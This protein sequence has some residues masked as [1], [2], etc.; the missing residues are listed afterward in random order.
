MGGKKYI[1]NNI[2]FKFAVD[3]HGLFGNDYSAAKA[4]GNELRGLIGY[5]NCEIPELNVPLMALVDYRGF[6]L[7]AM[8]ILPVSPDTIIY[9]SCDAGRNI[10]ARDEKFN[11]I[12]KKAAE[13]LHIKPHLCRIADSTEN[14]HIDYDEEDL[15]L[16]VLN[17]NEK[18]PLLSR[19][20][21]SPSVE[22][23]LRESNETLSSLNNSKRNLQSFGTLEEYLYSPADLEGH[24]GHDGK[25]YLLDFSRVLPPETP[26]PKFKNAHLTRLLRLEFVQQ[27]YK[28]LCPDAFSGFIRTSEFESIHNDEIREATNHL[29]NVLIPKFAKELERRMQ[30]AREQQSLHKFALTETIHAV[31]INCRHAGLLRKYMNDDE[32]KQIVLAEIVARNI[33]NNLRFKLREKMKQLGLPLEEPYRRLVIDYLN[34]VFGNTKNSD[35]YWD[36]WLKKD[37]LFNFTD[38]LSEEESQPSFHLKVRVKGTDELD[39]KF[40]SR[41]FERVVKMMGLQ[42]SQSRIYIFTTE[43]PFNDADLESIGE[44]VKQMNIM[45][46]AQGFFYQVN[47][48]LNRAEDPVSAKRCYEIAIKKFEEA[49]DSNPNNKDLL[50]SIS[51][52]LFLLI[53]EECKDKHQDKFSPDDPLVKKAEEYSL[54]AISAEPKYDSFSLFRY[55][56]FLERCN[57]LHAA[58]DYYLMALESD[59]DNP[60]C[61]HCYGNLLSEMGLEEYAEKFYMRSSLITRSYKYTPGYY[62]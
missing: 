5:F 61:L 4:A 22:S 1:V 49:L 39:V 45:A 27:Y 54:R 46:H 13:K 55:A 48:L 19:S 18:I 28:P 40:L 21:S 57:K 10:H 14:L 3:Y 62:Y 53:E 34:L 30:D 23:D 50:L 6:R 31:G 35:E 32:F 36:E 15:K 2:L 8:S 37:L 56:Q 9:G 43:K 51:L 20:H 25:Y 12:M 7:I 24:K 60:G 44:R 26:N 38:P 58:E 16:P 52:T 17:E 41:V 29:L 33:K 11:A 47:G 59:P 42:F